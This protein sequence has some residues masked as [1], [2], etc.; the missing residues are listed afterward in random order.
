MTSLKQNLKQI[1]INRQH[2]LYEKEVL[3][4]N[5][6]YDKWIREQEEKLLIDKSFDDKDGKCR[7][8]DFPFQGFGRADGQ[9]DGNHSKNDDWCRLLEFIGRDGQIEEKKAYLAVLADDLGRNMETLLQQPIPDVILLKMYS[10]EISKIACRL[11]E[12]CFFSNEEVVLIYGDEDIQV[13]NVRENPWFKPDWSPDRFLSGFYFG[14]LIAV[15]TDALR[16]AYDYC[17]QNNMLKNLGDDPRQLIYLLLY[18][19]VKAHG[20]FSKRSSQSKMPVYHIREVL[21]HSRKDGYEQVKGLRLPEFAEKEREADENS[22]EMGAGEEILLSVIIP[23][24]DNPAILFHCLDSLLERTCSAYR[25]E[26]ILVDNGSREENRRA[27]LNKASEINQDFANKEGQFCIAGCTYLYQPMEFNFSHMC[28]LGAEKA[29][30]EI[31][32]F[33]NDDMEIIQPDWMDLMVEKAMLPRTGA[34]GAKL[35]YPES[36]QIQ[37]AGITN[38]RVGPAHKLQ[39]LMD[40]TEHYFGMNRGVHNMLAATGACLM[41][42]KEVFDEAG[43]FCEEL[44]VAFN[45]VDLCYTIFEQGY[46]NVVRNDVI[47]YHH[48]SLSRGKDGESSEKQLRLLKEKDILYERH[49]DLYGKDPYYHPYLT[50][51]ML[52]SEY[53]PAYRYQVTLDM[54]WM[55]ALSGDKIIQKAREDKCLVVGMECAMDLYKWQYG[56][57]PEKGKIKIKPEDMGYYFQG[58]SFV[59]GADNACYKKKLLL[60]NQ[61][62]HHIWM[63]DVDNRYRRDIRDNL[64]D[65]LN[66]DLTGFAAKMRREE[67]PAGIYQF[68][69]LAED[70]CSR[71]KLVN[72]SNWVLE[73]VSDGKK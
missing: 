62:N 19:M 46:Y 30:G 14:G 4:K 10:G 54:P 72:W 61:M 69:M 48:E 23:S 40:G 22:R 35:L 15:R 2:K 66:V 59:I 24:K 57:A 64:K 18:Q 34:V 47:F 71:Q 43:G 39:F 51:D 28:N 17:K 29:K 73:V 33:L 55:A 37:H 7:T 70:Q 27:I 36:D 12:E 67:I 63:I 38:L 44:A 50:T 68:G 9:N 53:S 1:L 60:R 25:C 41:V 52:E 8:N 5:L 56:V 20:G 31:L 6:T 32:L 58:Y 42:R 65:Q 3:S 11:I 13:E 49:Q 26:I 16:E 45:D 21:Y